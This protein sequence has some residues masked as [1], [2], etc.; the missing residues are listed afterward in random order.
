MGK[1]HLVSQHLSWIHVWEICAAEH[2]ELLF[3]GNPLNYPFK[4]KPVNVRGAL[5]KHQTGWV[6]DGW[7]G[8]TNCDILKHFEKKKKILEFWRR[9]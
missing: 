1:V 6:L 7:C 4:I 5:V 2:V 9:R 3:M 8:E